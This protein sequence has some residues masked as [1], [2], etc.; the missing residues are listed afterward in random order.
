MA[1]P[2]DYVFIMLD[3]KPLFAPL[4]VEQFSFTINLPFLLMKTFL[5]FQD[6]F[7]NESSYLT[8][9]SAT[10]MMQQE[11]IVTVRIL[12]LNSANMIINVK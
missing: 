1:I 4:I 11:Q 3:N 12:N 9:S 10:T 7:Q 6:N 5:S 8:G 2:T